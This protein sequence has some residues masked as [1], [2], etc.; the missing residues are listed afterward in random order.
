MNQKTLDKIGN[1]LTGIIFCLFSFGT[2]I[3]VQTK[4]I[5]TQLKETIYTT[6]LFPELEGVFEG[7]YAMVFENFASVMDILMIIT[8][9]L[10]FIAIVLEIKGK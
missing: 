7:F 6:A 4:M 5:L 8:V 2:G 9:V 1:V 10:G 3:F